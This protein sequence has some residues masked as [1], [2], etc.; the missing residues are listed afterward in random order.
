MIDRVPSHGS[1]ARCQRALGLASVKADGV[2]YGAV[3]CA[4]AR[5]CP[6]DRREALV[7]EAA[8]YPRPRRHFRKRQ[9]KELR[10]SA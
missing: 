1:C 2:W 3:D 10:S 6:F 5:A 7:P 8:L 9:P 4:E